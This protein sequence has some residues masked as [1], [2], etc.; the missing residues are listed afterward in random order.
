M[1]DAPMQKLTGTVEHVVYSS[2][3]TGF[4]V[5]ELDTDGQLVTA[6]GL[7]PSV[8]PGEELILTGRYAAH[9]TYGHQFKVELCER[10]LPATATAIRKYLASGAIKGIGPKM[11][12]R[13]VDQ[14]GD[15]SLEIIEKEP[16]LLTEI[17]GISRQKALKISEEYKH[18]FGIRSVMLFLSKYNIEPAAAIRVWKQWGMLA[19]DIITGDPYQLC[20]DAVGISFEIADDIAARM[21]LSPDSPQRVRAGLLHVLVHNLGNGHTCLPREKLCKAASALLHMEREPIEDILEQ[22]SDENTIVTD[23]I[24]GVEFVYLPDMYESETYIAGRIGL[25]LGIA[26]PEPASREKQIDAL[27]QRLGITYAALQRKAITMALDNNIFILTGG[28]GTG[29]TTTLN[30][31]LGLLEESGAK[32][33]LAAPTGRA[34]KRMA[35]LCGREAKTIHRLLEVDYRDDNS[36]GIKFKRNEKNP[37]RQDTVILDEVSMVDTKLL[38]SLMRAMRLSA[39]LILVGDPDQ[40]PSVGAGNILQDLIASD[41]IPMVHLSEI[42]RQA[43][44]SSIVSNA[45]RIVRGEDPDLAQ[46]DNDFFFM[47]Q[48][49]YEKITQTVVDLCLTRLPK[50]YQYSPLWDIQVIVPSR[51]GALGTVELNRVLQ[52]ALNPANQG[53]IDYKFGSVTFREQ[54]KVMQVR[55]NYD[56]VWKKDDG[57]NGTGVFNGDIGIIEMIDRASRTLLVRYDDRVAEYTFDMAD[58]ME[59]AYAIT[60]HKS[61]GSEFEAVVMPLMRFHQKLYYRNILYTAVT[62]ARRMMIILGQ[63]DTVSAMVQNHR[64]VLRYTNLARFLAQSLDSQPVT[65]PSGPEL[66]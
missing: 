9:A 58:E 64:K 63:P 27:E 57:E 38:H 39:R 28:P 24:D 35:E 30:G 13:I 61:Q 53:K 37:L 56:I 60:V 41:I 10:T 11:A 44:E 59:H 15:Q 25:M 34:A 7:M 32:V 8:A 20:S 2:E 54:D 17:Q 51:I 23:T 49:T 12:I 48:P 22:A 65:E 52:D 4:T 50:A 1:A 40:L 16:E 19:I 29:K 21:D 14:F 31:I 6:V 47:R 5:L 66:A 46:R 45:H 62:R 36:P 42:F 43:Q 3:D 55:N 18:I 33:T 26:P